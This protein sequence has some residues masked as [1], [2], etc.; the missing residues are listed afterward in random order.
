MGLRAVPLAYCRYDHITFTEA[1]ELFDFNFA[2]GLE[3]G[4]IVSSH[5]PWSNTDISQD[6]NRPINEQRKRRGTSKLSSLQQTQSSHSVSH[7]GGDFIGYG[8]DDDE[9]ASQDGSNVG[10][11]RKR[12]SSVATMDTINKRPR[13]PTREPEIMDFAPIELDILGDLGDPLLDDITHDPLQQ[14]TDILDV[15]LPL[16]A[17]GNPSSY[18]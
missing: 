15:D 4:A 16:P 5:Y 13:L 17:E 18:E 7:Q 12:N 2:G 10:R 3:F 6:W 1:D 9:E 11:G 14:T 8:S